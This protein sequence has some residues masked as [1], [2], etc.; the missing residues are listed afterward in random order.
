[1]SYNPSF[2]GKWDFTGLH[3]FINKVLSEEDRENFFKSTLP[4][5][6]TIALQMPK[7]IKKPIPML[8]KYVNREIHLSQVRNPSLAFFS[9]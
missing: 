3:Y 1:M 6:Q 9:N 7:L 2:S 5:I 8:S 4:T